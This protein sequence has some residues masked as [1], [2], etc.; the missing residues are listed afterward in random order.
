MI[1]RH[2]L[3]FSLCLFS[4][5]CLLLSPR[6]VILARAWH[7]KVK[8]E[9]LQYVV[10]KVFEPCYKNA[11]VLKRTIVRANTIPFR[12]NLGFTGGHVCFWR[13]E[14]RRWPIGVFVQDAR[15]EVQ[16]RIVIA[17]PE[18]ICRCSC[19]QLLLPVPK[20]FASTAPHSYYL[21]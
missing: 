19:A 6:F 16:L 20:T 15:C 21:S 14:K 7:V 1:V 12:R 9:R 4:V 5:R 18:N 13:L 3:G 2:L 8:G 11:T 10:V 17:C